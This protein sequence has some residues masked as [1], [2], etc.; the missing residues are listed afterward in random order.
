MTFSTLKV[1]ENLVIIYK[2]FS[3]ALGIFLPYIAMRKDAHGTAEFQLN[4]YFFKKKIS[5]PE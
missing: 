2:H 1:L 3:N 5:V 4:S